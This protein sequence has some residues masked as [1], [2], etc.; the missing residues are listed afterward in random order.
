[1]AHLWAQAIAVTG[2]GD[3]NQE[4]DGKVFCE[5]IWFSLNDCDP[6][7]LCEFFAFAPR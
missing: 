4:N 2:L 1:L 7:W 5:M 3:G 6:Y